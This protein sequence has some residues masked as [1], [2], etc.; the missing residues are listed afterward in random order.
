ME[1]EF[2]G[3]AGA[4]CQQHHGGSSEKTLHGCRAVFGEERVDGEKEGDLYKVE[5]VLL[6]DGSEK[7]DSGV[8]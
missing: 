6:G 8:A 4:T 5:V 1:S 3:L 2:M 7:V